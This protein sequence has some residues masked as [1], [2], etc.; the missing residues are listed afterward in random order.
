MFV[1]QD[2]IGGE[3]Q[4]EEGGGLTVCLHLV[5]LLMLG[6]ERGLLWSLIREEKKVLGKSKMWAGRSGVQGALFRV[7]TVPRLIRL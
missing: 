2:R 1:L 6:V 7:G 4:A 5:V 3:G